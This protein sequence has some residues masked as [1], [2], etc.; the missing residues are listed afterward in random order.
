M[1]PLAVTTTI[2][3][4]TPSSWTSLSSGAFIFAAMEWQRLRRDGS[5]EARTG[6]VDAIVQLWWG[7]EAK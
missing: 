2:T 4:P 7:G 1:V 3:I 6:A 5:K